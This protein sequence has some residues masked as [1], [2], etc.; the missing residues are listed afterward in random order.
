[1]YRGLGGAYSLSVSMTNILIAVIAVLLS[2]NFILDTDIPCPVEWT[3]NLRNHE[4]RLNKCKLVSR[5]RYLEW[6]LKD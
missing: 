2:A 1:M 3:D 6:V 4:E 5:N